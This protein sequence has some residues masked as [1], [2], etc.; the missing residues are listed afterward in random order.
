MELTSNKDIE[1]LIKQWRE[2]L[3]S[4]EILAVDLDELEHHLGK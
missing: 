1:A 4:R 2:R 3:Y